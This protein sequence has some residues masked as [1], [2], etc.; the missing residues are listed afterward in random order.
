MLNRRTFLAMAALAALAAC[1]EP[2][3]DSQV[4]GNLQVVDVSVDVAQLEK[5]R[6]R[7]N[8]IA[9]SRVQSDVRNTLLAYLK[10]G[11]PGTRAVDADVVITSVNLV[12]PG[13][14]LV[15]GG[16][17]NIQGT[18]TVTD[19]TTGEVILETTE[20]AGAAEGGYPLGGLIGAAVKASVTPED[21]Y[22]S[23]VVGFS[24]SVRKSLFGEENK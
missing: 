20:V 9:P 10:E 1:A 13:Q 3:L 19:A 17:S 8:S 18:L 4:A 15:V 6:G 14:S 22:K 7:Q 24:K 16:T 23:T 21:D 12:S 11:S 2:L 5:V